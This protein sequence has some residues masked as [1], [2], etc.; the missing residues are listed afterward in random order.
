MTGPASRLLDSGLSALFWPRKDI[1]V[2]WE[3]TRSLK[4][5]ADCARLN[6][7]TAIQSAGSGHIGTSLSSLDMMVAIRHFLGGEDFLEAEWNSGIFFSSKGHDAPAYYATMHACGVLTDDDLFTLRRLGGLPGHPET[8]TP[9]VPTNTGSLGMGISKAKGFVKGQRLKNPESRTPV[10]VM[11]G[12]GELNEGQIWESMP[13][14]VRDGFSELYA[15]VDANQI[16]SDTWTESTLPMG[17]LRQRVEGVGWFYT[18]CDGNNPD[19]V[20]EV[21]H[22]CSKQ[23]LPSFIVGH[24]I[25]G[26]GVPWMENFP[27]KGEYY[28]FHSGALAPALYT[29][30]AN[31]L[32]GKITGQSAQVR[33]PEAL[34][35]DRPEADAFSPRARPESLL[36]LW[37]EILREVMRSHPEVVALDGDLSFDTGTHLARHDFPDRY[38]QAG[39]AEQD[40]VSMAGTLALSGQIPIVHSFATFLTMRAAEQIFN[41]A[42]EYSRVIY[43]GF[44]AGLVPSAPGFSHQ[45]VTDVGIMASIPGMRVFEPSCGEELRWSITEA[46][47]YE[48]PSYIRVGGLSP[49]PPADNVSGYLTE[50]RNGR[51]GVIVAS[52]PLVTLSALEAAEILESDHRLKVAVYSA[53]EICAEPDSEALTTL[54]QFS[55]VL[56]LENHNPALAKFEMIRD[57]ASTPH[58]LRRI[59]LK[60]VP[61]N[62]QPNEV[63]EFHEIDSQSIASVLLTLSGR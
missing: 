45:A 11:L 33:E 3:E 15:I 43:M 55:S 2:K 7:L 59:G 49:A 40:M 50:R 46:L 61:S 17:N 60:G 19:E 30:A 36:T 12:D 4:V 42:T 16:Q 35:P 14:A 25:K 41:N 39:I 52:G 20:L 48:G 27:E 63:M 1:L 26:S 9:G 24:T 13:G 47:A 34:S 6:A 31:L 23:N 8:V 54:S 62:G 22:T 18:E 51:D 21:L 32:V 53:A 56:V 29:T 57:A 37:E 58:V 44:L 38:I 10:F 5:V 28:K